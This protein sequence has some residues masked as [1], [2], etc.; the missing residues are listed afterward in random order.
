[1]EQKRGGGG[2][3]G[4]GGE[5]GG[6]VSAGEGDGREGQL[7]AWREAQFARDIRGAPGERRKRCKNYLLQFPPRD[8]TVSS[9][10][11]PIQS[12]SVTLRLGLS[13]NFRKTQ[14]SEEG[15]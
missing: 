13:N 8:V 2:G 7:R 5:G 9:F 10:K 15:V 1:M 14:I 3:D 4:G 11:Q 6:R 12:V